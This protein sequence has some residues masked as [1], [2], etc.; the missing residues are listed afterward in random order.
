MASFEYNPTAESLTI[1]FRCK[2]GEEI[3]TEAL[4]IPLPNFSCD[5]DDSSSESE[6]NECSCE[7]C[8]KQYD[9][10]LTSSISGGFGDISDLDEENLMNVEET[11]SE[12]DD[13]YYEN[14]YLSS[15]ENGYDYYSLFKISL[16][17]ITEAL[18]CANEQK[19]SVKKVFYRLLYVNVIGSMEAYLSDTFIH[20]ILSSP[21]VKRKF[22]EEFKDFKG[23]K[24][25]LSDLFK[26]AEEHD[27]HIYKVLRDIIYHQLPKVKALYRD[28]LG[29][30]LG[31]IQE[32]MKAIMTRHDIVH[33]NG[34]DINGNLKEITDADV[35]DLI[36]KT[37]SFIF[38]IEE[39]IKSLTPQPSEQL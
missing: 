19:R 4:S 36:N 12:E 26:K 2:C 13:E 24:F 5:T 33:R 31:N 15:L 28:I 17:E 21:A 30:D 3:T 16:G 1:T 7:K 6:Y 23:E 20:E 35:I 39:Q 37:G 9:I 32:L 38:N 18:E 22:T 10:T 11:Y 8:G 29:V 34:K 14:L 25:S 27:K